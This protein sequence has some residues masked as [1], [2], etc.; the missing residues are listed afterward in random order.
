MRWLGNH[1]EARD[2]N[3]RPQCHMEILIVQFTLGWRL[4]IRLEVGSKLV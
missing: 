3:L 2:L 4:K 1:A